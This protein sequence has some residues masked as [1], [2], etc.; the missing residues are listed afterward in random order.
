M[1]VKIVVGVDGHGGGTDAVALAAELAQPG[2]EI[3]LA[4]VYFG[5]PPPQDGSVGHFVPQ[6][7]NRAR[8]VLTAA[9]A[10]AQID[11]KLCPVASPRIGR[12]LHELVEGIGADLLV[13]GSSRRGLL[14]RVVHGDDMRAALNGS[15]CAV[16]IAP[17]GYAESPHMMAEIGVAYDGSPESRAALAVARDLATW[18]GARVSAFGAVP[19]QPGYAGPGRPTPQAMDKQ[20]EETYDRLTALGDVEAHAAYGDPAEELALYGASVDLLIVGSRGY[21]PVGRLIH[22]STSRRLAMTARCPLMILP[23][24]IVLQTP[25][26]PAGERVAVA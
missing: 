20:V 10:D 4:N 26:E 23:R 15:P 11:A 2:G 1:F 8:E 25:S 13:V 7:Y 5:S 3:N 9:R 12:G 21:G 19:L 17:V 14:G 18:Q 6:Q 24:A 22:G 16:A